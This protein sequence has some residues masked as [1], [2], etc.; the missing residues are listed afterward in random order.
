MRIILSS[1]IVFGIF[2]HV[3]NLSLLY[4][5]V[6]TLTNPC[7]DGNTSKYAKKLQQE[8][9]T[10]DEYTTVVLD[11]IPHYGKYLFTEGLEFNNGYLYEGTGKKYYTAIKKIDPLTGQ[12]VRQKKTSHIFDRYFGEGITILND[13][14]VQISYHEGRAYFFQLDDFQH[15]LISESSHVMNEKKNRHKI[16]YYK[17]EGWGLTKNSQCFIMSNGSHNIY[18]RDFNDFSIKHILETKV[19]DQFVSG[20]N[21]LEYVDGIIYANIFPQKHIVMID[22]FSGQVVG[23]ITPDNLKC[24]S[25]HDPSSVLNGIAYDS[26]EDVF[27]LTGKNCP[28]IYKVRFELKSKTN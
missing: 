9:F 24:N 7:L 8:N 20:M 18:F 27:Y 3:F 15:A 28:Y 23:I 11:K 19:K 2:F 26:Y 5:E 25:M 22:V 12:I 4:G 21:E 13:E 14:L 6:L 10:P 16:F 17:G 1:T